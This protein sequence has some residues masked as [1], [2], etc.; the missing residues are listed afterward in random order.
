MTLQFAFT[1]TADGGEVRLS[2]QK[3]FGR[4][5]IAP[6][7]W[8]DA[9]DQPLAPALRLVR[10]LIASGEASIDGEVVRVGATDLVDAPGS[11][12]AMLGL[13][14]MA[15]LSLALSLHGRIESPDG[16]IDTR[17]TDDSF[18]EVHPTR[19]GVVV[20]FAGR[21]G[22]LT[23]PLVAMLAAIEGYN[24][25]RGADTATRLQRWGAVQTE[26][27]RHSGAKI[28][29]D[30][31]LKSFRIYQA[32]SFALDVRETPS[33]AEIDPVPMSRGM[34]S[35]LADETAAP[36]SGTDVDDE[37]RDSVEHALL[38]PELQRQ[39]Q[40]AFNED[41]LA[42]RPAY[43][44]GRNT[45]LVIDP[46]VQTALDVVKRAQRA[47]ATDRRAFIRNPR[48]ALV[49]AMPEAGDAIGTLFVETRQYSERVVGLGLWQRPALEWI[50]KQ[51]PG[52]LP[53][54]FH[55]IIGGKTLPMT[56][57]SFERLGASYDKAVA[58]G[59]ATFPFDGHVLSVE[60]AATAFEHVRT[61]G[62]VVE[63]PGL[64]GED[65][66]E[67]DANILLIEENVESSEFHRSIRPRPLFAQKLFPSDSVVTAP[68]PHQVDGFGWLVDTWT[69]GLPGALLADD[70]GLGKTMQALAF[71]VW[72]RANLRLA[73]DRARDLDGPIL[74]VAPT[75]L[76]RN[77]QKEAATHLGTDA[78]G[79]CIEV[80]GSG[81][82]R[83]K[84]PGQPPEDAIDVAAL[85]DADWILT[86][87][88]TLANYHRAFARVGF[89]VAVF[90]EMQKVKAP[91]T[92]NT[93]AAK[94]INADFVLG[95]TGTP[96]ENRIEDLWCIMDR[97]APGFLGALKPFSKQY[98]D[99]NAEALKELKTRLDAG[100][101]GA[102][103][104]MLRRMK[105]DH[106]RG[107]PERR[108]QVYGEPA[109]PLAQAD[110]Y[111]AVVQGA[112]AG[113]AG[114]KLDMLKTVHTLRG[115]SLHPFGAA[116]ID[117]Y[118]AASSA[119]WIEQSARLKQVIGILL[120]IQSKG[121]K[122][123]VFIEDR[124]IQAA[125]AAVAAAQLR[126][127][128]EPE[129]IN[130]ETG[131]DERQSIVDRFQSR[132]RGFDLLVLSPK[133][134]GIGLTITAANHVIHL[135]RWWN[136]AVEDQ[137]NDR[138]FRIGQ[139]KPVTVHIPMAVHPNYGGDS[140]DVKLNALLERKRSLSRDMLAPPVSDSDASELFGQT[141][142][143]STRQ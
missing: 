24:E 87:Y 3:L 48:E 131:A 8:P 78:L 72:V 51:G 122:A 64:S 2:E 98:G 77:W 13:P 79:L 92:I 6:A 117:P 58:E 38:P 130:G 107:L 52:W 83:L 30:R 35:S 19:T 10:K 136:P 33:G 141:V 7:Q 139:D 103:P 27:E 99:S 68:K 108:F 28:E 47:P 101:E 40:K 1:P 59:E 128:R 21:D 135:S 25:T 5:I 97:V 62:P 143:A 4:R 90:D 55:F 73:G 121:E 110:A 75:A 61:G 133:A 118:D 134:A 113:V 95:M 124:A 142:G 125:F 9:G 23:G 50:K 85:R 94:T 67:P 57:E 106:L 29:A 54:T 84:R 60:E 71:L 81:L 129:I 45:Y 74:I 140:F 26:M 32:G 12:L 42:T 109:M 41:G 82:S 14:P 119:E 111:R 80:F 93:H 70:M 18:R 17:W 56:A 49:A 34:R 63:K 104:I 114:R 105:H 126:L 16:W 15:P 39:F 69:A 20:R 66:A 120:D 91:D 132:P 137:C 76:L 46:E 116:N 100:V 89:S 37:V 88:E 86:T 115:I 112:S 53:E 138:V 31:L 102:P 127:G 22:R 123:L 96:I 44:L 65:R 11:V 43:V 36:E